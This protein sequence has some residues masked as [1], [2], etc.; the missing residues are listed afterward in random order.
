MSEAFFALAG[1]L[2]GVL[3]TL[4]T[5]FMRAR[6]DEHRTKLVALQLASFEFLGAIAQMRM[7]IY[8]LHQDPSNEKIIDRMFDAHMQ[9]RASFERL[10]LTSSSV[11][12]QEAGR[13]I[14]RY[15][16][17]LLRLVQ[18]K[19]RRSDELDKHPA[20]LISEWHEALLVEIRRELGVTHPDR[21]FA[22]RRDW[23]SFPGFKRDLEI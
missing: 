7:I 10:R 1:A 13:Y 23:I 8:N 11:K 6:R 5:E 20:E 3:G 14:L 4:G 9:A 21:I 16:F 15:A 2:I 18:G 22:D 19:D 17:G 12:V